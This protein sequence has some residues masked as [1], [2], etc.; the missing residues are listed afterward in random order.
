MKRSTR[1]CPRLVCCEHHR[2][3]RTWVSRWLVAHWEEC[4]ECGRNAYRWGLR[5]WVWRLLFR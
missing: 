3:I 4:P 5:L 2:P 1:S